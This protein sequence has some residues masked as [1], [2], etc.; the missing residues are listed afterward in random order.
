[1]RPN[2][3]TSPVHSA[4]D[5]DGLL[6][7]LEAEVLALDRV[8]ARLSDDEW[9]LATPAEPWTVRDQLAHLA[10]CDEVCR[11]HVRG[12]P[13]N[14]R[15]EH[16]EVPE[17]T[18]TEIGVAR[19]AALTRSELVDWW[20]TRARECREALASVASRHRIEWGPTEMSAA[21]M[22]TAR[23]METWAHGLDILDALGRDVESSPRLRHVARLA[24]L[25]IP[26]ARSKAG[27]PVV[28]RPFRVELTGPEELV[29]ELGQPDAPN[30]IT[31]DLLEF[32][33][34]AVQRRTLVECPSLRGQGPDAAS[35]LS[36]LR[37]FA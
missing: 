10:D 31:G 24:W 29:V 32:C 13:R 27:L 5:Y 8:V 36:A 35:T 33:M 19:G 15:K 12:G 14:L 17:G 3:M 7:D 9:N 18:W 25:A 22:V 21:S 1:M 20:R 30:R 34:R 2:Q 4:L 28:D 11:D 23:L 6:A 26:Y 37:A 16:N